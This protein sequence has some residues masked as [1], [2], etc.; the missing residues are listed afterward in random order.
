MKLDY[1]EEGHV[2]IDMRDYV[3]EILAEAPD[4]MSG[5]SATPAAAHL[6]QVNNVDPVKLHESLAQMYHH[7]V[8]KS[9]F[10]SKRGRP[11]IQ[12]A[13]AFLS[14]RVKSPDEDD[15]KKLCVA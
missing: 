11:D 1:T 9:L 15:Y 12:T 5:E 6:F 3:E 4:D 8:A 2:K 7:I 13:V 10:L 14:T